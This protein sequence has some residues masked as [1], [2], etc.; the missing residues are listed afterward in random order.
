MAVSP[1]GKYIVKSPLM[2]LNIVRY[3][4]NEPLSY[5]HR[6]KIM[7][8]RACSDKDYSRLVKQT[9]LLKTNEN[10]STSISSTRITSNMLTIQYIG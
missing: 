10:V 5:Y 3:V 2:N 6:G 4:N 9:M 7:V 1:K 8:N